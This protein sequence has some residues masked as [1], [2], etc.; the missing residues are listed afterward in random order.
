MNWSTK[1]ALFYGVLFLM[2]L[3][4]TNIIHFKKLK[5]HFNT[6]PAP[7][8]SATTWFDGSFQSQQEKHT[9]ERTLFR[10]VLVRIKNQIQFSLYDEVNVKRVIMGKDEYLYEEN[11]INAYLGRDFIGKEKIQQKVARLKRI[12]THL[13]SKNVDLLVLFAAGKGTFYPEYIPDIYEPEVKSLSNYSYYIEELNRH[14]VNLMDV[15]AWFLQAKDTS[16][17]PLYPK[18]GI[19]WS[20]YGEHLVTDS[21]VKYIEQKR[22]IKL[23][24]MVVN[25]IE[26]TYKMQHRDDDIEQAMN[27]LFNLPDLKMAYPKV[28]FIEDKT[29]TKPKV[30][31]IADSFYW[32]IFSSGTARR[33]FTDNQFWYYNKQVYSSK[34]KKQ[35]RI[36]DLNIKSEL[37]NQDV[38]ILLSTDANLYKFP[39]DFDMVAADALFN[40]QK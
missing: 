13:K 12:Q 32:G 19:H 39:F 6:T 16:T 22:N 5:G 9:S 24:S 4:C 7:K 38:V 10:N 15:N 2:V 34:Y 27:L 29:T 1:E 18:C 14:Q 40:E 20:K 23:P 26:N 36:E 8:F 30:I 37:E 17:Y 33:L 21:L 11:Y 3:P 31:V 35:K 28:D 25:K